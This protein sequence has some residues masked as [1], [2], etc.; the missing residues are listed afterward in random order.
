[1]SRTPSC[2]H[3]VFAPPAPVLATQRPSVDVSPGLI[4][5]RAVAGLPPAGR[6]ILDQ[7][8]AEKLTG[9]A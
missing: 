1:M 8:G 6:V 2:D 4:G 5:Q 7:A 9:G 3:P